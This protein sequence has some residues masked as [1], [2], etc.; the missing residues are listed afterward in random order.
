[1]ILAVSILTAALAGLL[2][3]F[4]TAVIAGVTSDLTHRFALSPEW[5]GV[6]VSA[7]LWGT[8]DRLHAFFTTSQ[9]AVIWIY[10]SEIFPTAVRARGSGLGASTHWL[11]NAVVAGIFPMAVAWSAS[12][13]FVFFA[14]MMALQLVVV[15]RFFPETKGVRLE[16]MAARMQEPA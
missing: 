10:L 15:L 13:P 12:A 9:D 7:A 11:M 14:A 1:M 2:F 5:L 8:L 6:T 3:G 16:D 4:D